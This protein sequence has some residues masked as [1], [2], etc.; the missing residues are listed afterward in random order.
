MFL[1][2]TFITLDISI[3]RL[4]DRGT[5]CMKATVE[6]TRS[7]RAESIETPDQYVFC[8]LAI[9]EYAVSRKLLNSDDSNGFD[10]P[11]LESVKRSLS[12]AD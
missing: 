12:I 1:P 4:K 10:G 3:L 8:H 11:A 7:Q 6:K 9:I 5:V 2:G